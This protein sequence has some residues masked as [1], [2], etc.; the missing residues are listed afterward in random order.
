MK[1]ASKITCIAVGA[2]AVAASV[3]SLISITITRTLVEEALD[4]KGS[5]LLKNRKSLISGS[6]KDSDA[7]RTA[8]EKAA[9]LTQTEMQQIEIT[10][11][12]GVSLIGHWYPCDGAERIIVA[13]H[14]W[15]SNWAWDFGTVT[16]FWREHKCSI[17]YAEQRGQGAS[18]GNYMGFGMI[19]RYDCLDWVNWICEN[20]P[21]STPIYL[22][23]ISMGASTVLMAA[24]LPLPERV[25]GILAD[26]GFTSAKAIWQH[27]TEDNLHLSYRRREKYVD[28]LCRRRIH[29]GA[30]EVSTV[31]ALSQTHIPVLFIH[32]TADTFVPVEMTYENYDAC[33]GPKMIHIVEGANHGLSYFADPD[34]YKAVT[35][36]FWGRF[37]GNGTHKEA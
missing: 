2:A 13:M 35:L 5:R 14:G 16:E 24:D 34:G 1:N 18:G 3:A 32:G 10:A 7:Y 4:R 20:I 9:K 27:V 37:D 8:Q 26:C 19:E 22:A 30:E 11:H 28:H 29:C 36:N 31:K 6:V 12:D 23:G 17:L 21:G 25:H 33:A 15:R